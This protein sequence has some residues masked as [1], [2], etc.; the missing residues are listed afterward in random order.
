[1]TVQDARPEDY[2]DL[3]ED[4]EFVPEIMDGECAT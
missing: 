2:I 4:R 3:A 1:M